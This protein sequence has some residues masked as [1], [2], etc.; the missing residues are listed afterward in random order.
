MIFYLL[1]LALATFVGYVF[2]KGGLSTLARG[3]KYKS[4]T[5]WCVWRWTDVESEYI[6]RLH[7]VKT[8]WCALCLHWINKPDKEPWLHDHPVSF[9]SL[10]LRGGYAELRQ[11]GD[12]APFHKVNRWFNFV[13]A[14]STDR[15]RIIL[16][17]TNTLT[18]ALMGP[19]TREWGFHTWKELSAPN[20]ATPGW[21]GW[22]EYYARLKAGEDM[23][24]ANGFNE[25]VNAALHVA[26]AQVCKFN[27]VHSSTTH[28][29]VDTREIDGDAP[30]AF[31]AEPPTDPY[32]TPGRGYP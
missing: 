9:L 17:R 8:P 28:S 18:L 29:D 23:R 11:T 31:E 32:L 22:K 4:G 15:H 5:G 1:I 3:R 25:V 12:G 10:I 7:V 16:V 26:D 21:I 2:L 19:K 24:R 14:S 30:D 13:R 6:L 27:A 20:S